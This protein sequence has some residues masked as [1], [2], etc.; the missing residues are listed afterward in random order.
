LPALD[1]AYFGLGKIEAHVPQG[2]DQSGLIGR[3][4]GCKQIDV[5]GR[6]REPEQNSPRFPEEEIAHSPLP[7]GI[8]DF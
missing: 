2:A 5:L 7:E 6:I 8:A 3:S 1:L 4:C